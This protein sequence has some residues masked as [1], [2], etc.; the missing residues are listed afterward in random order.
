M[1]K[2]G[3]ISLLTL[4]VSVV[5]MG[6][7]GNSKQDPIPPV[8]VNPYAFVNASTPLEITESDTV[9]EI[10][11]QLTENGF[12]SPGQT[13]LMRPF[14]RTFGLIES[15]IV[16]TDD[17]GWAVFNYLSPENIRDVSGQSITLQAIFEIYEDEDEDEADD[18]IVPVGSIA[19]DFVLNFAVVPAG[20][21]YHLTNQSTPIIVAIDMGDENTIASPV[22]TTKEITAYVVDSDNIG[23]EGK[24][25]TIGIV[26]QQFGSI[27]PASVETDASGKASFTYTVSDTIVSQLGNSTTVNIH[28]TE[29]GSTTSLPVTITVVPESGSEDECPG[30]ENPCPAPPTPPTPP[31][32]SLYH[33]A[34]QSTPIVIDYNGASKIIS[35]YVLDANNIGV[36]GKNCRSPYA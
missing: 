14:D 12:G 25:V 31:V 30:S 35:V 18:E 16:E 8:P 13:V 36:G 28:Y 29:N 9:Y 5:M 15:E 17:S 10:R 3:L 33:L 2:I 11:V 20:N 6:C 34:N 27:S 26:S 19:Q 4:L 22:E 23:V 24:T 21:L 32:G 1:K 7:G